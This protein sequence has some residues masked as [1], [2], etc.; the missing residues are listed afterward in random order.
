MYINK[1]KL[2]SVI[3]AQCFFIALEVYSSDLSAAI[4]AAEHNEQETRLARHF[5]RTLLEARKLKDQGDY[6]KALTELRKANDLA[7]DLESTVG[8]IS[9][10]IQMS[11]IYLTIGQIDQAGKLSEQAI[12]MAET[13]ENQPRLMASVLN[14][15]GTILTLDKNYE[16]SIE[17]FE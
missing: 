6:K 12:E 17:A 4:T 2:I 13:L 3:L 5:D 8:M 7:N 14:S 9:V 16:G 15:R 1:R 11:D 10:R